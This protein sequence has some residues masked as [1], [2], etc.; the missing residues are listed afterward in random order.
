MRWTV[1]RGGRSEECVCD[2]ADRDVCC[3]VVVLDADGISS[4]RQI[5]ALLA[6]VVLLS[7]YVFVG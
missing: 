2:D 4:S 7:M 1:R 3:C 5:V 6:F